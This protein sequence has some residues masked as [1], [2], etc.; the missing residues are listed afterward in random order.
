MTA[1]LIALVVLFA[2]LAAFLWNV[3]RIAPKR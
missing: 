2:A 1:V 3:I